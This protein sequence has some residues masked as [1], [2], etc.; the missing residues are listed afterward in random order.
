MTNGIRVHKPICYGI[1]RMCSVRRRK[2]SVHFRGNEAKEFRHDS[3]GLVVA[4]GAHRGN[5]S[6]DG[7][8]EGRMRNCVRGHTS[9]Y[10]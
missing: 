6:A 4:P 2:I 5:A 10:T 9:E 3:D 8:I 1:A 7:R